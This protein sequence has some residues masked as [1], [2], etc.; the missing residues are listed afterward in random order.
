MFRGKAIR[1]GSARSD[2]LFDKDIQNKVKKRLGIGDA[3]RICLYVPTYRLG[4]LEQTN[5]MEIMKF[6]IYFSI[7]KSLINL[8]S[9]SFDSATE[10]GSVS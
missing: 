1:L 5:S 10:N 2:I 7:S 9:C 6:S 8:S 3:A 4:E